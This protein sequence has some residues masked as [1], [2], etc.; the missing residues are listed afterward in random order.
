MLQR[1]THLIPIISYVQKFLTYVMLVK[2]YVALRT[3]LILVIRFV[4]ML[5]AYV[6]P[7]IR[8]VSN[9]HTLI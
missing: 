8:Y 6:M 4:K 5:L 2:R 7:V 9:H 3:H 1:E